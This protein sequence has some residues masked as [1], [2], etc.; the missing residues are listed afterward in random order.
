ML[1]E[2]A[3]LLIYKYGKKVYDFFQIPIVKFTSVLLLIPLAMYLAFKLGKLKEK[4]LNL[5]CLTLSFFL[6]MIVFPTIGLTYVKYLF[7]NKQN[8][9]NE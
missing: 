1:T 7:S 5:L 9:S 8:S 4:L 3:L 6:K 2:R